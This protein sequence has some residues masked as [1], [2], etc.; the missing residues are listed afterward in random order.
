MNSTEREVVETKLK[1]KYRNSEMF[2]TSIIPNTKII[3]KEAGRKK[4]SDCYVFFIQ[5]CTKKINGNESHGS[6]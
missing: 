6:N 2:R 4:N 5:K 1:G 3:W